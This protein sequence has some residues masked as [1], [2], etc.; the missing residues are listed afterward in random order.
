MKNTSKYKSTNT[1]DFFKL[2]RI[3]KKNLKY[4]YYLL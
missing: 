3:F 4:L 2:V 1:S